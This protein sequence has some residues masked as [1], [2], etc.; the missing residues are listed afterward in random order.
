VQLDVFQAGSIEYPKPAKTVGTA[1][2]ESR[3][4][5]LLREDVLEPL[6]G[7][8]E[9]LL[10]FVVETNQEAEDEGGRGW[11]WAVVG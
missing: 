6:T 4:S 1:G 9:V 2:L 10:M 7:S 8:F 3:Q 11:E 5:H